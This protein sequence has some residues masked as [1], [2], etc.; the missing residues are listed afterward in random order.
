MA[1]D[2][3][4]IGIE[5]GQKYEGIYTTM[6][7]DGVKNAAPIGI[8]C[9]GKD[10]LGCRLFVGTKTLKNIME[11]EQGRCKECSANRNCMQRQGQTWMQIICRYQ[12]PQKHYGNTEICCKYYF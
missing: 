3:T 1:I 7:K 8:V 9:R 6:S 5:E 4:D 10:K 2:L 12:N 11:H